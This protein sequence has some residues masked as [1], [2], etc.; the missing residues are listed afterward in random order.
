MMI[1]TSSAPTTPLDT[2]NF[3]GNV[4]QHTDASSAGGGQN[5]IKSDGELDMSNQLQHT[6]LFIVTM[7][8]F[9]ML[10]STQ[11]GAAIFRRKKLF[12]NSQFATVLIDKLKAGA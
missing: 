8:Q 6:K 5:K 11:G 7:K 3:G 12:C 1:L 4:D 10:E 2:N 9:G